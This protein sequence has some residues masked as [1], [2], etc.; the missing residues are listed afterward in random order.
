MN[1]FKGYSFYFNKFNIGDVCQLI[2][3]FGLTSLSQFIQKTISFPEDLPQAIDF[4]FNSYS[5]QFDQQFDQSVEIL[6]ENF[7]QIT[8]ENFNSFSNIVLMKLFLSPNLI[9]EDEDY[10]F[11]LITKLIE[12]NPQTTKLL[13]TVK[14]EFVSTDL[15]KKLVENFSI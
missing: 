9:I 13:K 14:F 8:I 5:H 1:I 6:I 4:L 15:L 2:D 11:E 3:C 7:D 12:N 10:L